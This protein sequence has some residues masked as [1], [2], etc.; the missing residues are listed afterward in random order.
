MRGMEAREGSPPLMS[1]E[2]RYRHG[3]PGSSR[4]TAQ[5]PR[6]EPKKRSSEVR[7]RV[8]DSPAL[9]I[10]TYSCVTM[11]D[12]QGLCVAFCEDALIPDNRARVSADTFQLRPC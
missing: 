10:R 6:S 2:A 7:T 11:G 4:L 12:D 9:T 1:K 5:T 8:G 3:Q